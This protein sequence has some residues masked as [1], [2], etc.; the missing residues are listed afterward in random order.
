MYVYG[1]GLKWDDKEA[2]KWFTKAAKQDND[3]AQNNLGL[4]YEN[5]RGVKQDYKKAV[6]W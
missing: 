6:K 3:G 4:T 1:Q 5:G 2:Y